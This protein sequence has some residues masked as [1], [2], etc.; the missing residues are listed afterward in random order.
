MKYI[1]E[2]ILFTFVLGPY[3]S[4]FTLLHLMIPL[5]SFSISGPYFLLFRD[6]LLLW[7]ISQYCANLLFY[8]ASEIIF[9]LNMWEWKLFL[10]VGLIRTYVADLFHFLFQLF[11]IIVEQYSFYSTIKI[12]TNIQEI[13]PKYFTFFF[14][15]VFKSVLI[16]D[17]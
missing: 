16:I 7:Q 6:H 2:F 5:P 11:F 17:N 10:H 8:Q 14:L 13:V 4:T 3:K 12:T 15:L 1:F 9:P